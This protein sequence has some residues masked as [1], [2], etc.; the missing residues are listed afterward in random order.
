MEERVNLSILQRRLRLF[1]PRSLSLTLSHSLFV[2]LSHIRFSILFQHIFK[3]FAFISLAIV[4]MEMIIQA[5]HR[6][7]FCQPSQ[8]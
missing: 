2:S 6:I 8:S 3:G 5:H 4:V 7:C 1:T